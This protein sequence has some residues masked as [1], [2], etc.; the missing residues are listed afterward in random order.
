MAD[1]LKTQEP[2]EAAILAWPVVCGPEVASRAKATQFEDGRL[3]VEVPDAIWRNQLAALTPRYLSSLNELVPALV[4]E[5]KFEV[6][7]IG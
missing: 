1:F 2:E 5:L 3:T 6:K 7:R 4:K